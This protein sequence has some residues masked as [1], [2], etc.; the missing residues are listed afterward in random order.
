MLRTPPPHGKLNYPSDLPGRKKILDQR[1]HVFEEAFVPRSVK[2]RGYP[3]ERMGD[4]KIRFA[5]IT[6]CIFG[7]KDYIS[8]LLKRLGEHF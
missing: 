3:S 8:I 4:C 6:C 2:G 5:A 7:T 1:M